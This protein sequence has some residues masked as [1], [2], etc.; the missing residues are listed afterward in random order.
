M[1]Y[2]EFVAN[3]MAPLAIVSLV[4]F[5]GCA[6]MILLADTTPTPEYTRLMGEI[7]ERQAKW[8]AEAPARREAARVA[9]EERTAK[10]RAEVRARYATNVAKGE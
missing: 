7:A 2:A 8:E 9:Y 6:F 1:T 5:V 10:I 3:P 4:V